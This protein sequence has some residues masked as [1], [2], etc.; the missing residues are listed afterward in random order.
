MFKE[1]S[2]DR[3]LARCKNNIYQSIIFIGLQPIF[4]NVT[5]TPSSDLLHKKI[6]TG[7]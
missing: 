7:K 3:S 2:Q 5:K 1:L 4:Q 6:F